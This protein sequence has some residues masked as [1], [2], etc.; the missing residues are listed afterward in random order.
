MS[1]PMLYRVEAGV[2]L[3]EVMI[4]LLVLSVGLLGMAAMLVRAHQ[5]EMESY[6]RA[7]ALVL[8]DDIAARIT[9]NRPGRNCYPQLSSLG[10]GSTFSGSG[11]NAQ[12]SADLSAWDSLLKGAAETLDGASV[13]AMVGAR[14]CITG[15]NESYVVTV[16]WQGLSE[17]AA[18]ANTCG[19]NQYG[20][21]AQRRVVSRT[22]RFAKLN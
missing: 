14:G 19:Q 21:D 13:G 6:Q 2:G 5:A 17:T 20:N 9:A 3:L 18:P 4:A 7:Q 10:S 12:A 15:A 11:C 1:K 8:L 22:I 16:A